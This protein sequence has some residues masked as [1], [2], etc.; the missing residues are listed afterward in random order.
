LPR[1]KATSLCRRGLPDV[2]D[3]PLAAGWRAYAPEEEERDPAV[4]SAHCRRRSGSTAVVQHAPHPISMDGGDSS[5]STVPLDLTNVIMN[6]ED[7]LHYIKRCLSPI[8][9]S[10]PTSDAGKGFGMMATNFL[11]LFCSLVTNG[12][13]VV[14]QLRPVNCMVFS[15]SFI[16]GNSLLSSL[17]VEEG[18][19]VVN[20]A[21]LIG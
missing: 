2:E 19:Y 20:Q 12:I 18:F 7:G 11:L 8:L 10:S 17:F 21:P 1:E 14:E 15:V 6:A 13:H 9:V 4:D 3:H 16:D 5:T